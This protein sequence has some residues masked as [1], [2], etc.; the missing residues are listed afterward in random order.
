MNSGDFAAEE[1]RRGR[2]T[3][4]RAPAQWV[5]EQFDAGLTITQVRAALERG[6]FTP[7]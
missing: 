3:R 1:G 4:T 6:A 5:R 7:V 2:M